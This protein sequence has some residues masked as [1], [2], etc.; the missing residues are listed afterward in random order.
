PQLGVVVSTTS[1]HSPPSEAPWYMV[2]SDLL[3]WPHGFLTCIRYSHTS[4]LVQSSIGVKTSEF[5][6]LLFGLSPSR[7]RSSSSFSM[8][9]ARTWLSAFRVPRT[10]MASPYRLTTSRM[11]LLDGRIFIR[12]V[13]HRNFCLGAG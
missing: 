4:S 6:R 5:G 11:N 10:R 7:T 3:S 2:N 9:P 8:R 13:H 1:G 12:S